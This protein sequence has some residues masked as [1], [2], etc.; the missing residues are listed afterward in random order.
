MP[1][2]RRRPR[3]ERMSKNYFSQFLDVPLADE[4]FDCMQGPFQSY[5][6]IDYQGV[7]AHHRYH[8]YSNTV[9]GSPED[10]D[11]QATLRLAFEAYLR[12]LR[13]HCL[14]DYS[15]EV[16]PKLF[17][18]FRKG[19]H[20]QLEGENRRRDRREKEWMTKLYTRLVVPDCSLILCLQCLHTEGEPHA[21]YCENVVGRSH[22][23]G[24]MS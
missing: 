14:G 13:E 22:A 1:Y 20:I 6:E 12:R 5:V 17:W 3:R 7:E 11:V 16:K 2:L 19:E 8:T 23:I 21:N 24:Q 18:R 10:R 4:L 15:A 9:Y